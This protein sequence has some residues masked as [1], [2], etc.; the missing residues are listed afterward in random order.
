MK[1]GVA[2]MIELARAGAPGRLPLL[3]A[4]GG[5][6]VGEPA[7]GALRD[8]LLATTQL[9]VVLEPTDGILHAGCLGNVQARV[10]FHG[11]SAHSAR[12]WTGVNAIHELVRGL[13]ALVAPRAARRRARRARLPRGR[14]RGA[15]RRRHRAERDPGRGERRAELPLRAGPLARGGRGAARELVP[16]G[17]LEILSNSP[18]APPSLT[19]PLVGEAA[20]ARARRRAEAGV[21]AGRA[22]RRAGHRRDQLRPGRDGVRAQASTSRSRSRTSSGASTTLRAFLD[23]V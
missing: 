10:T 17:E 8:R 21:D 4:R 14:E 16:H 20:R 22:V 18:S 3:H 12:P 19:N 6:G 23:S 13:A 9:A 2:V 7:A 15:G 11:E 5:A 1:G